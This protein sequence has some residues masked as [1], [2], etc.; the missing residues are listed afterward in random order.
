[1]VASPIKTVIFDLGKVIVP[2]DIRRGYEALKPY[3]PHPVEEIPELIRATGIVPQFEAGQIAPHDF[4]RRFSEALGMNVSYDQFCEL[5]S[6]IFLPDTIIPEPLLEGLR[7]RYRLLLLSNTNAIHFE[8]ILRNYP[9]LKH[10]DGFV[11]SYEVG[12]MKPDPRIYE[13][14]VA[15][16]RCRPEEC[17]FTDDI[18]SYVEGAR[19]AG[20]HAVQFESLP[21]LEQDLAA[22]GIEWS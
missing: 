16:A 9:V 21:Q 1:M 15:Q 2:F 7:R 14:A 6:T 3:C 12:A 13:A 20:I 17:F 8:M 19:R 22:L 11:L 4:V 5:W 10:F 18:A